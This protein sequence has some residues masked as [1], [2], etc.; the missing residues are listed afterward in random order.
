[1]VRSSYH[2]R[3]WRSA[4]SRMEVKCDD[5]DDDDCGLLDRVRKDEV[6]AK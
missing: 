2:A 5:D 1:V 3:E 4:E 6:G